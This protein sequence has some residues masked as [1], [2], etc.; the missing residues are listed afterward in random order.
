MLEVLYRISEGYWF[1]PAELIMTF[2]F[3]F[4]DRVHRRSLPHAES[5]PLLF[6]LLLCQVLEHIGFP[7]EP[8]LELRRCCE[9]TL[10]I[11][12]WRARPQ[13]FHLPSPGSDEDE[14]TD[15]SPRGDLSPI[16]EHTGEP[17]A[18]ASPVPPPVS[19]TPASVPHALMSSFPSEPSGPMPTARSDIVGPSTSAPPPQ[20]ITLYARDFLAL[21]ET[22]R[23]FSATT[24]SFAASQATLVERMTC[25]EVAVAQIQASFLQ[26]QSHLGLSAVSQHAPAK[27]SDIPPPT[28]LAPPPSALTASLDVLAAAAASATSPAAPQPAQAED[29][30][31]PATD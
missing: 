29:H 24:T 8:R 6:P 23:T 5:L 28:G 26:L 21:M 14:P 4:E 22:V 3:H 18:P 2:L 15:D 25:T 9:A 11:D 12:R 31:S 13:A 19:S 27:A 7:V 1:S 16:A 10:A 30:P 20:Y 17:P